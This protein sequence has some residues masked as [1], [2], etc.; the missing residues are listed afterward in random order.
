MTFKIS[1][2]MKLQN[3]PWG[4]GNQ[5]GKA[6]SEYLSSAGI[7]VIYD[8]ADPD[9][10][11]ILF[12]EPRKNTTICAYN[13]RDILKY[14]FFKNN[15]TLVVH[16]INECDER[17]GTQ[18]LNK[19][20]MSANQC[21]DHTVF[22]SSWL[23]S[24]FLS[25]GID[26][27]D[28]SIILNGADSNTF[29]QK[30]HI[31]WNTSETLRLVTHHWGS[32]WL[33]GFDIYRKI[34]NLLDDKDFSSK[35]FLTFI[36]KLPSDFYFKNVTYI[37]PLSGIELAH[38]LKKHHVYLTASQYEPA[39]MHHI[40]GALCGLPV[41]YRDTGGGISEYCQHYGIE[42]NNSNLLE[43]FEEMRYAYKYLVERITNYP[44]TSDLMCSQYLELFTSII[45]EPNHYYQKR[46]LNK[47]LCCL[48]SFKP[49]KSIVTTASN[50]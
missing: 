48:L 35:Y 12:C 5:F 41:L 45:N 13:H 16:R 44:F 9:I 42:F 29:N 2:G 39:G 10:D 25:K 34:D 19:L 38:E 6:L 21:A 50:P 43:K 20:I 15:K 3:G 47:Y 8:L 36:G 30:N 23:E 37:P 1:I 24:L 49:Y 17:K 40:E 33:K 31:K 11:I 46:R 26:L 4:G 27:K 14:L 28:H 32:G 18:Y 22:I 7:K